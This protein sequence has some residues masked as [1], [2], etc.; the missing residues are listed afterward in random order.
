MYD[1]LH[2]GVV[3]GKPASLASDVGKTGVTENTGK[4]HFV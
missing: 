2:G 4:E 1:Y 3:I